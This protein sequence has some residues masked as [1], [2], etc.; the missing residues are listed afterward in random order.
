MLE[1]V[2]KGRLMS[3]FCCEYEYAK[4]E[5]DTNDVSGKRGAPKSKLLSATPKYSFEIN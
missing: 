5:M 4:K 3:N 1:P 2:I